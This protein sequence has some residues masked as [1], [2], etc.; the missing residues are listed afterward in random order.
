MLKLS[1]YVAQ[2][3]GTNAYWNT[4]REE[5][6]AIKTNVRTPTL[7]FNFSSADM[8]WP[9][10]HALLGKNLTKTNSETRWQNII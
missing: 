9:E 4:V 3:S 7:F 2:I 6:K 10:L 1:R 8:H 5:L